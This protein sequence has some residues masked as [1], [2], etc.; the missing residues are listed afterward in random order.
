MQNETDKAEPTPSN[1][2][3]KT[4]RGAGEGTYYRDGDDHCWRL[5]V[6]PRG[7]QKT[8]GFARAKTAGELKKLVRAE[9]GR[10]ATE[11]EAK[12]VVDKTTVEYALTTWLEK[13][14]DGKREA[15]TCDIY[16]LHVERYI[17]PAIGK[18]R[19]KEVNADALND[20]I[21]FYQ[22][23]GKSVNTILGGLRVA[24][25]GLGVSMKAMRK[26]GLE[27]PRAPEGRDR[28]LSED[29][30]AEFL[31][32]LCAEKVVVTRK[33]ERITRHVY[34]DRHLLT[35][36]LNTG[37]R[38]NEALGIVTMLVNLREGHVDV[39]EQLKRPH[40]KARSEGAK[41]TLGE[42]K[43]HA[44]RIVP[45][46]EDAIAAVRAQIAMVEA[47]KERVETYQDHG[48]LFATS[49]GQAHSERNVLRTIKA[50]QDAMNARRAERGEPAVEPFHIH[51]LRRSFGT[52][53]ARVEDKLQNVSAI[54]GHADMATTMRY[55]VHAQQQ[56][57]KAAAAKVSFGRKAS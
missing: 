16:R 45:L 52:H 53:L 33:G 37:L 1:T 49:T 30:A 46:N 9:Q 40:G 42:T 4:S 41:W 19:A 3:K 5:R 50:V 44:T 17:V 36:L 11:G 18:R 32:E 10:I 6:G 20:L 23:Q 29:E 39:R 34:R 24:C 35:F 2:R 57:M 43:S 31:E 22:E 15:T 26:E 27:V 14:V 54:L 55:Y 13:R 51:D 21:V 25:N 48:L 8:I 7:D 28:V 12:K 47:D 38:V 56:D